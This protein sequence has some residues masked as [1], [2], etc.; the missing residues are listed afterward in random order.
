MIHAFITALESWP[1]GS[2]Q[3]RLA[4]TEDVL[5]YHLVNAL[6]IPAST[7]KMTL[8]N[9]EEQAA[10]RPNRGAAIAFANRAQALLLA[11]KPQK[12]LQSARRAVK[13]SPAYLKAHHREMKAL[14]ALG[15]SEEAAEVRR[16]MSEY[17]MLRASSMQEGLALVAVGW[18]DWIRAKMIY[19]PVRFAEAAQALA[20]VLPEG[21]RRVECRASI[22]PFQ[23]G[24]GLML[25]LVEGPEQRRLDC[26]DFY[27]VDTEHGELADMPPDGHASEQALRYT[28][29][30]IGKF[31]EE[32]EDYG[33]TTVSVMCGQGLTEHVRQ[34][35][36]ELKQGSRPERG[37]EFGIRPMPGLVVYRA[38]STAASEDSGVQ[39]PAFD[40]SPGAMA[41]AAARMGLT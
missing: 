12:A 16:E 11:G 17:E 10:D 32:L 14:E 41:A 33:L 15:L 5:W 7:R 2:A 19:L 9:G 3:R 8:P 35:E 1:E 36:Q 27:M 26:L 13:A 25:S 37:D 22:V 6:P 29:H 28:P 21:E 20:D 40:F 4:E 31:I 24:Q 38:S 34:V 18:I 39:P 23:R 30:L